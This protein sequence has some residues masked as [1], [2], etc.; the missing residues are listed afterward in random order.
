MLIA[1]G[2]VAS[3]AAAS[4]ER[5]CGTGTARSDPMGSGGANPDPGSGPAAECADGPTSGFLCLHY[6]VLSQQDTRTCLINLC[7]VKI[8]LKPCKEHVGSI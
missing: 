1:R 2:N 3:R 7:S 8:V 4:G 6:L 5:G